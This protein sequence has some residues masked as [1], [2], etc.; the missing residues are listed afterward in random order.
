ML[1]ALLLL[2]LIACLLAVLVV[3]RL[4]QNP[5]RPH[6]LPPLAM[7][8]L[9]GSW[10]SFMVTPGTAHADGIGGTVV[11]A[12]G[13]PAG[14]IVSGLLGLASVFHVGDIIVGWVKGWNGGQA[15]TIPGHP[16]LTEALDA[17][18][19]AAMH[20]IQALADAHPEVLDLLVA[21]LKTDSLAS[22]GAWLV[23]A[24]GP[25]L[26]K[27]VLAQGK[28]LLGTELSLIFGG[29]KATEE[30]AILRIGVG[31]S[32]VVAASGKVFLQAP[33]GR[34]VVAVAPA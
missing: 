28:I 17:L 8:V 14:L 11:G 4:W 1:E 34:T 22:I 24:Y 16:K 9:V 25:D 30:A 20:V 5:A 10:V 7:L 21:K 6:S 18:E 32:K 19:Q 29:D 31:A 23:A 33:S 27:A 2:R 15:T 12:M 13:W 3:H 26:L